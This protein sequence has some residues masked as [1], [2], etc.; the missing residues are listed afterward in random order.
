M[1]GC[2]RTVLEAKACGVPV[3]LNSDS[4]KLTELQ[5]LTREDILKDWSEESYAKKL[6][7]GIENVLR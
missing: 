6:K 5:N 1:G 3:A 2:Q 4:S 7:K